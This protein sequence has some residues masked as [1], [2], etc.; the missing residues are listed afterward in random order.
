MKILSSDFRLYCSALLSK[1]VV[2]GTV[3]PSNWIGLSGSRVALVFG[4]RYVVMD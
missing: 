4:D 1:L 2:A 3:D